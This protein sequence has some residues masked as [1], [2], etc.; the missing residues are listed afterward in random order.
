LPGCLPFTQHAAFFV[1]RAKSNLD[2]RRRWWRPVSTKTPACAAIK[3][4]YCTPQGLKRLP[5]CPSPHQLLRHRNGEAICLFLTN[6]FVLPALTA[7]LYK[8]RWQVELFL[9]WIK[10]HPRIKAFFGTSENAVKTQIWITISIYVLVAIVKKQLNI[11]RSLTVQISQYF[12][13][14]ESR[15][16]TGTYQNPSPNESDHRCSQLTYS[17]YKRTVVDNAVYFRKL[18]CAESTGL[19]PVERLFLAL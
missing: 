16:S 4:S 15:Y 12:P 17:T 1:I 7:Q 5:R 3:P 2:Y 14:R 18:C 6:H 9:K 13:L 8:C 19:S 11:D 10:Q